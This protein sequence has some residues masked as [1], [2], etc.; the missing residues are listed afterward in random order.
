ME[1]NKEPLKEQAIQQEIED[2]DIKK[3]S[4]GDIVDLLKSQNARLSRKRYS[5]TTMREY[6]SQIEPVELQQKFLDIYDAFPAFKSVCAGAKHHHWWEGGLEQHCCEMIGV[7]LDIMELYPGDF[8]TFSKTDLIIAIFLHDFAKVWLYRKITAE[9]R[10]K[11]P[12]KFVSGQV[13]TFNEG[14]YNILSP[15][16]KTAVELMRRGI[17]LTDMQ[18]SAVC[19]AEGGF[20]ADHFAFGKPSS[21]SE[22]IYKRNALA[23]FVAML[24]SHSSQILGRSLV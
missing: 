15:E 22:S 4:V 24:D 2:K 13:F 23:T 17:P 6:L 5:N 14:V 11:T 10:S 7:G 20:S 12:K 9:D 16:G 8:T 19:F 18:W 21:T 1:E 3:Y